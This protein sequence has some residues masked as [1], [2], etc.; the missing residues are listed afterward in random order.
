MSGG[1]LKASYS[2]IKMEKADDFDFN[3]SFGEIDIKE[4]G[5]MDAKI[6][7]AVTRRNAAKVFNIYPRK[8]CIAKGK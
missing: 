5:K 7:V 6:F 8:G 3:N 1:K 2:G 4:V